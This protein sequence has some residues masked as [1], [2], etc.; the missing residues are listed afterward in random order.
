MPEYVLDEYQCNFTDLFIVNVNFLV[1]EEF[2]MLFNELL[3][4]RQRALLAYD[5]SELV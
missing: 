3:R 4:R 1:G 2:Y 5:S